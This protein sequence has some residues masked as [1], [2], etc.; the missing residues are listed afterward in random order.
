MMLLPVMIFLNGQ[1]VPLSIPSGFSLADKQKFQST[2]TQLSQTQKT[3]FEV[4][5][6]VDK[7]LNAIVVRCL[8]EYMTVVRDLVAQL[9]VEGN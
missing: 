7:R 6:K 1:L 5:L 3:V 9:G 8:S 2:S 4:R